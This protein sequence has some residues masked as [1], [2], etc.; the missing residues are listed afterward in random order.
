VCVCAQAEVNREILRSIGKRGFS[1]DYNDIEEY[2]RN[3]YDAARAFPPMPN[4]AEI[5]NHQ[6]P[7]SVIHSNVNAQGLS[8]KSA[9]LKPT[10]TEN[11]L[12]SGNEVNEP[13]QE[14]MYAFEDGSAS[15]NNFNDDDESQVKYL[16]S[17][18]KSR[19][20]SNNN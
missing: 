1:A 20:N 8:Q 5:L 16:Y 19:I 18:L 4:H 6:Q 9:I 15:S 2:L 7:T 17:L 13:S 3:R 11:K 14:Q 10:D 12:A